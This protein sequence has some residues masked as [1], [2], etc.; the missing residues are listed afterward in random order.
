MR[1]E[2]QLSLS[3]PEDLMKKGLGEVRRELVRNL[4]KESRKKGR[5]VEPMR[6]F[7]VGA[8]HFIRE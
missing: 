8:G 7:R 6:M 1:H 2:S 4:R 3:F 5:C